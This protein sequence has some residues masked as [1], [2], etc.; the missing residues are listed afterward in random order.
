MATMRAEKSNN[1]QHHRGRDADKPSDIPKKGW[2]DIL[3]R[4][5]NQ[6]KEDHI[7]I[8]AAGVTFYGFLA[9]FP[10]IAAMV[11]VYGLFV[12][13]ATV[14]QQFAQLTGVLPQQAQELLSE[15]FKALASQPS[16][17]L[18]VG[19]V[20]SVLVAIWSAKKG[21]NA[22]IEGMN[23][24]YDEKERRGFIKKTAV[25]LVFTLGAVILT[26]MAMVLVIA[27]PAAL[28]NMALSEP[29]A[30]ALGGIRWVLLG[31]ILLGA[32]ATIYRYAPDRDQPKWHWVSWGSMIA[33]ALWLVA[34]WAFSYYV[35]NFGGYND[36]YGS[37]A[38]VVILLMWL[39]ISAYTI[40]LGAE[41]NSEIEHQT[42]KDSTQ[43]AAQPLGERHAHSADTVGDSH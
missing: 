34:S 21:T 39:F 15:Q 29:V 2:K 24:A 40:L 22:L 7:S 19:L 10:A 3:I 16:S 42:T 38:A 12:E 30:L 4:V 20:V 32:L 18:G 31:A 35:S 25:T 11:S 5:K 33:V 41:I 9:I 1:W 17:T 26:I 37:L 43:G 36:T 28:N 27:L 13:P 23:I 8:V 6:I 14:E